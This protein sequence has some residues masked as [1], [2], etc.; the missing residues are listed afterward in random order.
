M[1]EEDLDSY[2]D[3]VMRVMITDKYSEYNELNDY[4]V[5]YGLISLPDLQYMILQ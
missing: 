5:Y 2:Y 4:T 1:L 3:Q